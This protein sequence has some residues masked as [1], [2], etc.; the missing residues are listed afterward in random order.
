MRMIIM[1]MILLLFLFLLSLLLLLWF[2][3]VV[4]ISG[5]MRHVIS[6]MCHLQKIQ[7]MKYSSNS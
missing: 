7:N 6:F 3:V 1:I 5:S 2:L 4:L